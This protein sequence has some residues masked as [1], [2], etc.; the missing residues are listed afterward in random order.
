V[1]RVRGGGGFTWTLGDGDPGHEV[2]P[3]RR[4]TRR[5]DRRGLTIN[6]A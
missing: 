2:D 4:S 3:A 5:D 6:A 1:E